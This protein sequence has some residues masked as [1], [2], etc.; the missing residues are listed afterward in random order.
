VVALSAVSFSVGR[1]T[2][3]GEEASSTTA[4]TTTSTESGG[5]ETMLISPEEPVAA[6]AAALTPSMVQIQTD[7]GLGS[8][9]IFDAGGLILTAAHVVGSSDRVLV[10]LADG[11]KVDG[12]VV[13]ADSNS[14]VAVVRVEAPGLVAAPL[15]IDEELLPGQM[16]IAIGS[17]FGLDQTVTAGVISSVSRSVVGSDGS[18]RELIQTDAPIN[19]GNSGGALA[20]R[21]AR[22]IG[23]NDQIF[24]RSGGNEGVGFAIPISYAREIADRLVAGESI[25][26]AT[27]GVTGTDPSIGTAGGLIT[28][29]QPG[30]PA[31]AAGLAVGDLVTAVDGAPIQSFTD[32]AAEIRTHQPGDAIHLTVVRLGTEVELE[33]TLGA[34]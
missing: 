19:P 5:P 25:E 9:V 2:T 24:S 15:A 18:V 21:Q 12:T 29:V 33:A 1:I 22:V 16:A 28:G 6:V 8:G 31:V 27:L 11:S 23:I 7:L 17:P 26:T 3:E 32:L 10:Q 30:S 4:P 20:D 14:D 34:R 13:G